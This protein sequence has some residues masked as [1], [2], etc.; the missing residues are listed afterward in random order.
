MR[1]YL[2]AILYRLGF[3]RKY[4]ERHKDRDLIFTDDFKENDKNY[5]LYPPWGTIWQDKFVFKSNNVEFSEEGLNIYRDSCDS[6]LGSS[7]WLDSFSKVNFSKGRIEFLITLYGDGCMSTPAVWLLDDYKGI[8]PELDLIEITRYSD[9]RYDPYFSAWSKYKDDFS[10]RS[11]KIKSSTSILLKNKA[12]ILKL[13]GEVTMKIGCEITPMYIKYFIND[14]CVFK[15]TDQRFISTNNKAFILSSG[16]DT[17]STG[18]HKV[19][20]VKWVK[21]YKT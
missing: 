18:K 11:G 17:K 16:L 3:L 13:K 10:D 7:G 21:I 5:N 2:F 15:I 20:N 6:L 4:T 19:M 1:V 12:P 14:F 9:G 8:L